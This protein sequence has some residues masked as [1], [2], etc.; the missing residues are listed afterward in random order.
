M[1][2]DLATP[3]S[4]RLWNYVPDY[5]SGL[6]IRRS[7]LTDIATSRNGTEQRR[8][9]RDVP[10]LSM[11][12]SANISGQD[13]I[14][15]KHELRFAQNQPHAVPDYSRFVAS[16]GSSGAGNTSLTVA[17]PPAWMAIGQLA[18]LCSA[19]ASELVLIDG[20]SGSTISLAGAL[21]NA[22]PS[23]SIIRP[24]I[25]GLL[26]GSIRASR[27]TR[28]AHRLSINVDAYPGGE[29][30][31][32]EGTATDTFNG[33]EVF[34]GEQDFAG[35]TGI[36]YIWPV[37]QVDFG[38]G[39]TA[40]FRPIEQHQQI[41]EAAFNS[42]T[43]AE[44]VSIEQFWLRQKGRRGTFYRPTC[45]KDMVLAANASG[46]TIDIEGTRLADDYG[47]GYWDSPYTDTAIELVLRN[48]TRLRRL[49][50]AV[51]LAGSNSRLS[52][53]SSTTA[54]VA[55]V[56][57]ISWMPLCRFA[58]DDLI[59]RWEAPTV[60]TIQASFQSVRIA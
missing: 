53:D 21:A 54:A 4:A 32:A 34:T 60:A 49:I 30:P 31:E 55:D 48:G 58:N 56:A 11:S 15:A 25:H 7:F 1:T 38:I 29:P 27:L 36:S 23:G 47:A 44:A 19:T 51:S 50:N 46:L 14:E 5:S 41:I 6:E 33:Y 22:W 35:A 39:R 8:A 59:T 26:E 52:L 42:R 28:A 45:E 24:V 18:F 13:L 3:A 37:E 2:Y 20:V 17:S 57:R 10:R 12:Y 16:T 43:R 9:L 40:Q